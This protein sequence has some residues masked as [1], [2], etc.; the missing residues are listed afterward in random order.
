[1]L[2]SSA[3]YLDPHA[4][5]RKDRQAYWNGSAA[6]VEDHSKLGEYYHSRIGAIYRFLIP[7]GSRVLELGCGKG[8]LLASLNPSFGVGIDFSAEMVRQACKRYPNLD[9]VVADAHALEMR[10]DFDYIILSDL[11]NDLWDAETVFMRVRQWCKS[12]DANRHQYGEP[13]LGTAKKN[14]GTEPYGRAS[15]CT[16]LVHCRGRY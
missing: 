15:A 14:S 7:R 11:V 4:R 9:F 5:Y 8:G 16:E 3:N 10:T 12:E 1:M 2:R 13:T 6:E